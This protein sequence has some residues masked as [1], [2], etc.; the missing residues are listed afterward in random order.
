MNFVGCIKK[1]RFILAFGFILLVKFVLAGLFSSDYQ[2]SLFMPFVQGW[3]ENGGNPYALFADKNNWFPYPPLMLFIEAIGGGVSLFVSNNVFLQNV[4]FKFSLF[5]FDILCFVFLSRLFP[6]KRL[7]IFVIY[8][9]SP[10]LVYSTYMHGQLDIIPTALLSGSIFFMFSKGRGSDIISSVL[11]SAALCTKFHIIA[12]LPLLFIFEAKRNGWKK[13]FLYEFFIPVFAAVIVIAPFWSE[14]FIKNVIFNREQSVLTQVFLIFTSLRIYIPILAVLLIYLRMIVVARVN[15]EL[16]FGFTAIL[17]SVFLLLVPPMPGWYLWV[18]PFLVVFYIDIRSNRNINF[19]I[20]SLLN[21]MYVVYFIFAHDTPLTD[22]SFCGKSLDFIKVNNAVFKNVCF[23]ML[24][25]VHAYVIYYIYCTALK[26]NSLYKRQNTSFIIGI[27]GDS[28]SGK[29][30][31]VSIFKNLFGENKVLTLECDG[32]HKWSRSDENWKKYTHLNPI[33]NYLYR[34]ANDISQLR[35]G[36]SVF[37]TEYNHSTGQFDAPHKVLPKPY[38]LVTGLHALYLPQLR[39]L[40]KLKIYM[41]ID[42]NLRRFWKIQRDVHNRGHSINDVLAQ[43]DD[44]MNDFHKYI[45]PQKK[46]ADLLIRYFDMNLTDCTVKDYEPHLSLKISASNEVNFEP[47]VSELS[48]YGISIRYEFDSSMSYQL[49]V[50]EASNFE[51]NTLP[52]TDIAF[53]VVPELEYI[54]NQPIVPRNDMWSIIGL[55]ILMMISHKMKNSH[56]NLCFD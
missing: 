40:E 50:F 27:S 12:V 48:K 52:V 5:I 10:I 46:Y 2:D 9:C 28:G 56:N 39:H 26:G 31:L 37:R 23:T 45:E 17:F 44:R 33:A 42:E 35:S 11:I 22:L 3:L 25:A 8:F 32:D 6:H 1:N 30:T 34:Q 38:I 43:I 15:R 18:L 16:F 54:L 29:S 21:A 49:L 41:D 47:L 55:V 19:L 20:F 51:K 14:G 24:F 36:K 13:A 7:Q 4:F 53:S